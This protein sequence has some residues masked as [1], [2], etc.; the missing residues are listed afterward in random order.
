MTAT[1][2]GGPRDR[3]PKPPQH[4]AA[5]PPVPAMPAVLRLSSV[6]EEEE[7]REPLFYIDDTEYTIPVDPPASIGLESLHIIAAGKGSMVAQMEAQDYV[8]TQ[9]LGADGW[10]ALRGCKTVKKH[11]L[12]HL[13]Q[14]ISDRA[15]AAMEDDGDPNP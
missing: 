11:E 9:M 12:K 3:L 13:I 8:M 1:V 15:N 14:I 5:P 2:R 10:A 4:A 6:P 7:K